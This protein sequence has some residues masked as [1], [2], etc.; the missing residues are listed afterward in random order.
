VLD[1]VLEHGLI[2]DGSGGPS[3]RTDLAIAGDRIAR[4]GDCSEL[5]VRERIECAGLVLAPGFIDMHG[6][7]DEILLVNPRAE[8][9]IR[10]G[11]TTE[12]GGNCG[13]SAGP[14]SD[15]DLADKRDRLRQH[16]ALDVTWRDLAGFFAALEKSGIA[17]NFCTLVGLGNTRSVAGGVGPAPLD[18][19][20]LRHESELVREA[21]R[22]GAI[23]VSSGLIYPPGRFADD[24]ELAALARAAAEASSPLYATHLRSEGDELLEAVE[25][26]LSIGMRADVSVQ[27]SH[28][29]ASGK[30]NWGKVHDT[31]ALVERARSRGADIVLDQYPYKAS[32]TGLDALLPADVNVGTRD[33]VVQRLADPSYARLV[34]ARLELE[35]GR[36]WNDILISTVSTSR[37]TFA[38]GLTAAELA[39]ATGRSSAAA[40]VALLAEERLDVSAIYFTMCEPDVQTVLSYRNT[41]IGTDASARSVTGPTAAGLP[42]PRAYG[43]FPRIFKRYVR[44]TKLLTL[45]EAVRR[46]AFLPALRLGLRSRGKIAENW[47]ADIIAFDSARIADTAT[48]LEPHRYPAGVRDVF[49]NGRPVV[50]NEAT[51]G[52]LAGRVL[53][54]GRDL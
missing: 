9:K 30:R 24:G 13:A 15:S 41:C 1:F 12:V 50:R 51:T 19:P 14:L 46:A 5:D 3:F 25:E 31:L 32:S 34:V 38:E 47:Y 7:S 53:R 36:D 26:A 54:R 6:H 42:H 18:G 17:M 28:H 52:E 33:E 21:C 48:Y 11:I 8:S 35:H 27:L 2:V 40:V 29:K 37:N 23:G 39:R 49:V 43:T 44:D 45:E 22:Q 20:Q 16:Y 10:Q 4:I